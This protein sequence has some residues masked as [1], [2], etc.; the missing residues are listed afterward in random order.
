MKRNCSSFIVHRSSFILL[1][2][3]FQ[4]FG[5]SAFSQP[6]QSEH[7]RIT[8][9]VL[10]AG[11]GASSSANF[12][13]VSAFGQPTPIG[14]SSSE[15]FLLTAGFLSPSFALSPLSPIQDLV[16]IRAPASDNM[17]L[18]WT[19]I[20]GAESYCVYR[21]E[22]AL[23]TPGPGNLVG[24]VTDTTFID[25]GIVSLPP[26][27]YYYIVTAVNEHNEPVAGGAP[28]RKSTTAKTKQ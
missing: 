7:F 8:K 28:S 15:N 9:S 1:L 16:I 5:I 3:A 14:L 6:Q 4:L 23:F 25:T 13:L 27:K 10:D 22:N 21:D 26:L 2:S 19:V 17:R 18:D 20:P 11:G 12:Q 24:S